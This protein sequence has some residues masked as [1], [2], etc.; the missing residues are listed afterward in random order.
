MKSAAFVCLK[1][2]SPDSK[3]KGCEITAAQKREICRSKE[4]NPKASFD[5]ISSFD[6]LHDQ[7]LRVHR[8]RDE[9]GHHDHNEII[10][11]INHQTGCNCRL[12]QNKMSL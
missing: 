5:L 9:F 11:Q 7:L 6:G 10:I 3:R 8:Q 2:A 4:Q 1:M 12:F